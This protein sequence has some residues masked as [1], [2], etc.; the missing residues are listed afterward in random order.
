MLS[1]V[2]GLQGAEAL[3]V[4]LYSMLYGIVSR[5]LVLPVKTMATI[6][7]TVTVYLNTWLVESIQQ[8]L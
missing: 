1:V 3:R 5:Q 8:S 6:G 2:F 4:T 7:A